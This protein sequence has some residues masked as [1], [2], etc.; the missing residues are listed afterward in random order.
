[1][2]PRVKAVSLFAATI[3]LHVGAIQ[4]QQLPVRNFD[5]SM[6]TLTVTVR[7]GKNRPVADARVEIRTMLGGVGSV[8]S[9]YTNQAGIFEASNVG[10]GQYEVTAQKNLTQASERVEVGGGMGMVALKL[11]EQQVSDAG[12]ATSVSVAQYKVPKKAREEFK[13]AQAAVDERKVEEARKH[14]VKALEIHPDFAEALTLRGIMHLEEQNSEAAI[15]DLDHAIKADGGY[16]LAYLALGAAFNLT[17]RY[18]E[19][20]RTLDRGVALN[21]QSWQAY[22]EIGKAEVGKADYAAAIRSLDKAESLAQGKYPLIH[23]AKAH[24]MLALKNYP[25][26]MN[27]LQAFIDQAP[28]AP[29]A[30]NAR[31]TLQQVRAYVAQQ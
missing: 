3:L 4:A 30:D 7:D 19:A 15:A 18:D 5:R 16:V 26:A 8:P 9:G 28:K 29:Q 22:F 21:P 25:D 2:V 10:D 27:E 14:V 23:L 17:Q 11:G 24:A 6:N 1:M 31:E 13:K 20:L 12:N